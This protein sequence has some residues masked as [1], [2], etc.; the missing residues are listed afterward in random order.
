MGHQR[1]GQLQLE[2]GRDAHADDQRPGAVYGGVNASGA[3]TTISYTTLEL[4]PRGTTGSTPVNLL[5]LGVQKVLKFG[6]RYQLKLM[7]D[8]FNVFNIN[9][10]SAYSSGNRSLAGYTQPTTIIAPR[11]FRFNV[12]VVF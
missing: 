12:R 7:L 9:T 5:D 11:V 10:I 4:E 1:L 3:A 8:A 6:N 2:P